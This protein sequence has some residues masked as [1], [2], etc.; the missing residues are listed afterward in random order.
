[1]NAGDRGP[2]ITYGKKLVAVDIAEVPNVEWICTDCF[3]HGGH[4]I[5]LA[6]CKLL[7]S[8][9]KQ[10]GRKWCYYPSVAKNIHIWRDNANAYLHA[11][12]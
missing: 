11:A 5:T 4:L 6:A 3:E 1:M 7:D 8:A 10:H 2:D 12:D 9:L